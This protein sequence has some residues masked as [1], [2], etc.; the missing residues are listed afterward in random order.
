MASKRRARDHVLLRTTER[1]TYKRCRQKWEWAYLDRLIPRTPANALRFGSLVHEA[2]AA[3][4]VP[5]RKRGPHPAKT[6]KRLYRKQLETASEFGMRDV[7]EEW[8]DAQTLGTTMLTEYIDTY[9]D[10]SSLEII[11]PEMPFEIDVMDKQGAYL[12][13]YVGTFDAV[14]RNLHTK[15]I[16]L[17]EHKTAKTISTDHLPL[18]EQAGSYWCFAPEWLRA[19]GILKPNQNFDFILYN[20]LRKAMPDVRPQNDLGQRLNK[21]GSVSKVQPLPLFHREIVYRD[22]ADRATMLQRVRMEAWEMQQVRAGKLPVYK[23]PTQ[24]CSW[25]CAFFDMCELHETGADWEES[26]RQLMKQW[27]PYEDHRENLESLR[28]AAREE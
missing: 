28:R 14:M 16:G 24:Q 15:E 23:N 9:G 19:Q 10:D 2:L 13:T 21:D 3:Y 1:A 17:F 26:R 6:F 12:V 5:G 11:A 25:D 7:D 4:Y 8:V 27:D 18:D 22:D 20:F